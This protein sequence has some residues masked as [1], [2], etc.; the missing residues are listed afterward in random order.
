MEYISGE[1]GIGPTLRHHIQRKRRLRLEETMMVAIGVCEAMEYAYAKAQLVHRDLKPE[2]VFLTESGF[3]KVGDFGLAVRAG[4]A[5]SDVAGT[6]PY[7]APE[8]R[9]ARQYRPSLDIYATG[10]ILYEMLCGT[11]PILPGNGYRPGDN[12][13]EWIRLHQERTYLPIDKHRG[14]LPVGLVQVVEQCLATEPDKRFQDFLALRE[15]L[16]PYAR[17]APTCTLAGKR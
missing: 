1:P 6:G 12:L 17:N 3:V 13:R 7:L 15:A 16:M 2:N 4:D 5:I 9:D 10:V 14:D 8:S 11:L